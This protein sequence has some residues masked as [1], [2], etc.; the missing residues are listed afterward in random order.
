MKTYTFR[1]SLAGLDRVWRTIE[2]AAEQ[3]LEELHFAIQEAYDWDADH[4]Y[5]FF[6]SGEAWDRTT[7]YTLPD[8]VSPWDDASDLAEDE[9]FAE[10]EDD[11]VSGIP[12]PK[13]DEA[14][15]ARLRASLGDQEA[16]KSTEEMFALIEASPELRAELSKMMSE[17]FGIP[18]FMA[19]MMLSNIRSLLAMV[20]EEALSGLLSGIASPGAE[21]AGD[22]RTTTLESLELEAG[23]DFLYLFDYGDEWQFHVRVEAIDETADADASYPRI[24]ESAGEA[25]LQ[26]SD[27]EDDEDWGEDEEEEE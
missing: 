27:W 2:I 24:V 7:E 16:P 25:P 14:T 15:A 3:T 26:Y 10:T 20:P 19:D 8:G 18:Q 1:V 22:V 11:E 6:L 4:L 13:I 12:E 21:M 5:S 9:E 17:Q 23:Q